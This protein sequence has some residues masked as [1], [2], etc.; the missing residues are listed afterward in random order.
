MSSLTTSHL[1]SVYGFGEDNIFIGGAEGWRFIKKGTVTAS[2]DFLQVDYHE[3]SDLSRG[4]LLGDEPL[5][6]LEADVVQ[7]FFSFWY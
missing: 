5:Y 6:S 4:A 7:I 3:F 2:I 1:L